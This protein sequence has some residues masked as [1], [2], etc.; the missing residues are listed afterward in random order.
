MRVPASSVFDTGRVIARR[1]GLVGVDQQC[2]VTLAHARKHSKVA[3]IVEPRPGQCS[4]RD[5]GE[6]RRARAR[7]VIA[8]V[9]GPQA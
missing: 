2:T 7:P 3:A 6:R 5:T 8:R 4:V 9:V 1:C